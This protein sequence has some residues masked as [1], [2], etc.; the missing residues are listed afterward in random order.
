MDLRQF[1]QFIA[2]AEELSFRRAAERLHMA[3]P[4]LTTSIKKIEAELG[5]TLLERTNKIVRLTAPGRTFLEEARRTV[6]QAELAIAATRRV[7]Q[8]VDGLVRVSFLPALARDVLPRVLKTF[9]QKYP[10]VEVQ[11]SEATSNLQISALK[12]GQ[13]DLGFLI[14]PVGDNS[15]V[16]SRVISDN[17]VVVMPRNHRLLDQEAISLKELESEPWILC[18]SQQAPDFAARMEKAYGNAGVRPRIVQHAVQLETVVGLVAAN[19]GV[20]FIPSIFAKEMKEHVSFKPLRG[21]GTPIDYEVALAW[22]CGNEKPATIAFSNVARQV[23][24]AH[25]ALAL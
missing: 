23:L 17:I 13:I 3:Q 16:T 8:G 14:P 1:R 24:M 18:P 7:A 4:P 22:T 6:A 15:I 2:V 21:A 11:L 9:W 5:V 25:S 12:K 10:K 19:I 20:G